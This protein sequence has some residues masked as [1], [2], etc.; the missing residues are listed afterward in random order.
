M[1][2][3]I[4][5]QRQRFACSLQQNVPNRANRVR[6]KLFYFIC[7][8]NDTSHWSLTTQHKTSQ[9]R[10]VFFFFCFLFPNFIHAMLI[11]TASVFCLFVA[12]ATPKMRST[13]GI[14]YRLM[15]PSLSSCSK[16]AVREFLCVVREIKVKWPETY[17]IFAV[18]IVD[19]DTMAKMI[20]ARSRQRWR[21]WQSHLAALSLLL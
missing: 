12:F 17:F 3:R 14:S 4:H 20:S 15:S 21:Q 13:S 11:H 19:S 10:N 18:V 7:E 2:A 5:T 9:G 6:N 1:R 8:M 16:I